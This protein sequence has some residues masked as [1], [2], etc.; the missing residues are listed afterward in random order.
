MAILRHIRITMTM[1]VYAEAL[2]SDVHE[3]VERMAAHLRHPMS[4]TLSKP[5]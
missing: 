4:R 3:A 2:D 1:D 5:S